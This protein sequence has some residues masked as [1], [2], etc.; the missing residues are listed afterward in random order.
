[1]SPKDASNHKIMNPHD[2]IDSVNHA[3]F[4]GHSPSGNG[5]DVIGSFFRPGVTSSGN[6]GFEF[7]PKA[8]GLVGERMA[9]PLSLMHANDYVAKRVVLVGDAAH[10]VHPLAGQGVNMGYGDV[11]SLS[12]VIGDGV[13]VGSDIGE[14]VISV[15]I[16]FMVKLL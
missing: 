11:A 9:F 7:P 16:F 15:A 12:S 6:E 10:T 8:V 14:V 1:M 3:L 4:S 2:F 13:A 5:G